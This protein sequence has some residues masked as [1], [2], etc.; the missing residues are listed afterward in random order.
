LTFTLP[1]EV[2][3]QEILIMA[4]Q[5]DGTD[6]EVKSVAE[7]GTEKQQLEKLK[8]LLATA[9]KYM[10]M[11]DDQGIKPGYLKSDSAAYTQSLVN[12]ISEVVKN[13]DQSTHT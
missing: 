3:Q 8:E 6:V 10:E 12:I 9:Q 2:S 11:S 5:A 1:A 13:K 7:G 4:A